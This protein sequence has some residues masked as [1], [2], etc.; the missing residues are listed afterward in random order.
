MVDYSN[1]RGIG[2]DKEEMFKNIALENRLSVRIDLSSYNTCVSF[3]LSLAL[4]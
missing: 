3:R 4:L 1:R 2:A